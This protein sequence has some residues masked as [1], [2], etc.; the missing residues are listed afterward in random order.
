MQN[1]ILNQMLTQILARTVQRINA[2]QV[3]NRLH[4]SDATLADCICMRPG[5]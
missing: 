4:A 5:V 2:M 1:L 3:C